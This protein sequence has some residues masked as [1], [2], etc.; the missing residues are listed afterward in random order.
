MKKI[1]LLMLMMLTAQ[2][3]SAQNIKGE[4]SSFALNLYNGWSDQFLRKQGKALEYEPSGSSA[5]VKAVI[6]NSVD[7]GA[8][9]RPLLRDE[10]RKHGFAQF[11][12]AIGGVVIITNL[13]N[14][15]AD[16]LLLDGTT[17]ADIYLGKIKKWNDPRIAAL[18]SSVKLPDMP[19]VPVFRSDGSGTSFVFTSYLSKASAAW[20]QNVGATSQLSTQ[21]GRGFKGN[22]SVAESVRA[23]PGAIGYVEYSYAIDLS[24]PTVKMKNRWGDVVTATAETIQHAM[25]AA[26][27]EFLVIDQDPTFELDLVDAGCPRCWPIASPTYV[28]VPVRGKNAGNSAKVLDFF[29]QALTDG[30]QLAASE[31]YVPLPSR[32]KS[33]IKV[34]MRRWYLALG[35]GNE[36]KSAR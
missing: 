26:D 18:N 10:L 32:A 35:R 8:S 20:K 36:S 25:R 19:I 3:A 11:P 23:I 31:G 21:G 29:Q 6:A 5:G 16:K 15:S 28:L 24:V 7:F 17:L 2:A 27:W 9:D 14:I 12:T 30:D 34:S 1:L 4:G 22:K 13:D 33:M